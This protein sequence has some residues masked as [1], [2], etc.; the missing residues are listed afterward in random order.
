MLLPRFETIYNIH[1]LPPDGTTVCYGVVTIYCYYFLYCEAHFMTS[2]DLR[3]V[4][5][6]TNLR[7]CV[8]IYRII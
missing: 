1:R 8:K 6:E 4:P 3:F 2:A 5:L 7:A